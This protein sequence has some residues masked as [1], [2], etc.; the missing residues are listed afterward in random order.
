L[1]KYLNELEGLCS[2]GLTPLLQ[3]CGLQK[4]LADMIFNSSVYSTQEHDREWL[5]EAEFLLSRIS[6]KPRALEDVA[7]RLG[8]SYETFRHRFKQLS[9]ISP[10]KFRTARI[11]EEASRMILENRFSFKEIADNLGFCD[12]FHFSRRF[13][14]IMGLSPGA[15]RAQVYWRND[16]KERS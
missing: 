10:G 8:V 15:W 14:G 12:E 1:R 4:L 3:I 6:N 13:K 11:M 5:K 9:G 16:E 7:T 2:P